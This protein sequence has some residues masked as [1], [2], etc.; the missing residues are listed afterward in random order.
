MARHL[1]AEDLT[2]FEKD[3]YLILRN[4]L[5]AQETIDLQRY[6][7][8]VHDLPTDESSPW[9]PYAEI[10]AY[11]K[12]VLCRTENYANS[13]DGLNRLLRGEKLLSILRDLSGQDMLLF[14]EKINYKLAGAG[15]FAA[16]ID[17]TAYNH[18]KDIRHLAINLA[19]DPMNMSN[20]GL[21]VVN[22]SHKMDIPIAADNCIDRDWVAKQ[23]WTP[24]ELEAG[25]V[26]IFG[27]SLAHRSAANMSQHDRKAL[28]ATYNVA[29]EGDLH[30]EYYRRRRIEWPPTHL[31]KAGEKFEEGALR[32]GYGSP[33]LSVDLGHQLR[34]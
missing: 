23:T 8:E 25:Q 17:S 26:L 13:H 27:S 32:Y 18:V 20:G 9:M 14:K 30:D 3:G 31:R 24:V 34:V 5:T 33:M 7:Q 2:S 6:A 19:V 16:H 28:Y 22:G 10:D 15:G 21:E 4:L 11:G 1:S 29:S 12:Q